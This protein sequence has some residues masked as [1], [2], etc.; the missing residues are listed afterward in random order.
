L[1][2]A[3]I[4]ITVPG[5]RSNPFHFHHG[6]EEARGHPPHSFVAFHGLAP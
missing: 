1:L 6:E 3:A 2:E 4:T 5:S